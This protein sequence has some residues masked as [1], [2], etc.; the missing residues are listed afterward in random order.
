VIYECFIF[1]NEKE[2]LD[3][4]FSHFNGGINDFVLTQKTE[5]YSGTNQ[6]I[7]FDKSINIFENQSSDLN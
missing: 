7:F 5:T 1:S 3:M 4:G 2:M 6:P